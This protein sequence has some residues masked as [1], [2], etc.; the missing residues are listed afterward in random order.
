[1]QCIP[2]AGNPELC[3]IVGPR[4]YGDI[5]YRYRMDMA[6]C[7]DLAETCI[8]ATGKAETVQELRQ[9]TAIDD[10]V[11]VD[12]LRLMKSF[13]VRND[14]LNVQCVVAVLKTDMEHR[15]K[16]FMGLGRAFSWL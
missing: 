11:V 2:T 16:R 12:K 4:R 8:E 9:K 7:F 15:N 14:S 10:L 3:R 5:G 6:Q 1:M 13:L